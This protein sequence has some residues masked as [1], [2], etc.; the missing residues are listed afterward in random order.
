MNIEKLKN[1][2]D[3]KSRVSLISLF[4]DDKISEYIE[5]DIPDQLKK[6]HEHMKSLYTK[7]YLD[8]MRNA[9]IGMSMDNE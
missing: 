2:A 1:I 6:L 7:G 8:C 5:T 9:T 3:H 4:D